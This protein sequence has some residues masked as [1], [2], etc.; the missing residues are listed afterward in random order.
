MNKQ[1]ITTK[2]WQYRAWLAGIVTFAVLLILGIGIVYQAM[3]SGNAAAETAMSNY[4]EQLKNTSLSSVEELVE[5]DVENNA[6][7]YRENIDVIMYRRRA[8]NTAGYYTA[9]GYLSEHRTELP[10]VFDKIVTEKIGEY[11][12]KTY[13][14]VYGEGVYIKLLMNS[15]LLNTYD[16]LSSFIWFFPVAFVLTMGLY[17][18]FAFLMGRPVV[19]AIKQ[20]KDFIHEMTHEI[21]TPLTVIR[22]NME[23][24]LA[25]P[26][27]KVMQVSELL[28]NTIEEVEH[29]NTLSQDLMQSVSTP[30]A[31]KAKSSDAGNIVSDVLEVYS[32]IIGESNRT[33]IAN[34]QSANLDMDGEKVKQL[35]IILLENA[36]KYTRSGDKI[37]V[38]LKKNDNSSYLLAVS[39]T[40]IGIADGEEEK[41]FD[42]FYRGEN[43]KNQ[44]GSGLGLSIAR[45][46]VED[47]GGRI[48]VSHNVPSGIVVTAILPERRE[49]AR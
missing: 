18:A 44:Q 16:S 49:N 38:S 30:S 22:G 34:V 2:S 13:T 39:D 7:L 6:I 17:T 21:R 26:D 41:I 15:D 25:T 42:R 20:Q 24:I 46:I 43:A 11:T 23:N 32:E 31:K 28:E 3:N 40:G 29:I 45:T 12:Y 35:L 8:D 36:V 10:A 27:C 5:G 1:I 37:K 47:V 33:L 4:A 19:R 9:N 14:F 48:Y